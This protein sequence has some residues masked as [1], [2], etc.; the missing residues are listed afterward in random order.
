MQT[1]AQQGYNLPAEWDAH[2]RTLMQFLPPQNW[3]R[4]AYARAVKEWAATANAIAEF[5]PVTMAV[6]A[7]DIKKAKT[8]L[9]PQIEFVE[10]D[11]NDGWCRDSGP[12]VLLSPKGGRKIAGIKFNGWGQKFPPYDADAAVIDNYAR[13][14]GMDVFAGDYVLE[15]GAITMDGKG[16]L[17]TTKQCLLHPKRN[18]GLTLAQHEDILKA[19]LGAKKIIWIDKGLT[20]DPITDGHVDGL[21]QFVG[22]AQ[23]MVHTLD[24]PRDPNTKIIRDAINVLKASTDAKGRSFEIIEL[25]LEL[26]VTHINFY[27][28]NGAVIVPVAGN[29][30][31]DDKALSILAA[32]FPT[33]KIVPIIAR[34][35]AKGGGGIHCIT[36]EVPKAV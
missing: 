25:P 17:V 4:T 24:D 16:T 11:L 9:D 12:T 30:R 27:I 22:P 26:T 34:E 31:E 29:K 8:L 21:C 14:L 13:H 1:A 5:E 33:R 18:P 2:E 35:M 19:Q 3:G 15:A 20:P 32:Q 28:C 7:Q 10:M 36:H 6:R 23:I